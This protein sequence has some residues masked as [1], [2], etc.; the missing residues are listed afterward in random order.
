MPNDQQTDELLIAPY[1]N[2]IL[3]GYA[4]YHTSRGEV[5]L[6][7]NDGGIVTI[8]VD[9]V[10]A[11]HMS[12]DQ[13]LLYALRYAVSQAPELSFARRVLLY[14][15]GGAKERV[16]ARL[17]DAGTGRTMFVVDAPSALEAMAHATQEALLQGWIVTHFMDLTGKPDPEFQG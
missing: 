2:M 14:T 4:R 11:S 10:P 17:E 5:R 3:L 8:F 9:D 16:S 6:E 15:T 1:L 12:I 13:A 7:V